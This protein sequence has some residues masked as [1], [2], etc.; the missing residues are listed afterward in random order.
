MRSLLILFVLL[1]PLSAFAQSVDTPP[2]LSRE[3]P[4]AYPERALTDKREANVLLS[5]DID[6]TGAVTRV[7][8]VTPSDAPGYGFEAAAEEALRKFQFEPAR[9]GAT[10]VAVRVQ[11]LYRFVLP[12]PVPP[13]QAPIP[14]ETPATESADPPVKSAPTGEL[15]GTV[16]ERGSRS[17]LAGVRVVLERHDEAYEALT[18]ATGRFAFFDLSEGAWMLT[19]ESEG[20]LESRGEEQ[21]VASEQTEVTLYLERS[22]DNPYDVLVESAAP[23][24]DVTRHRLDVR[25]AQTQP[26]SFGDPLM[27]VQ[28]LPGV[29]VLNG[30]N[31]GIAMRGAAPDESSVYLEGFRMP[32]FYHFIGIRSLVA[33]G[34]LESIDVYPGGAP[35][36]YGRQLGGVLEARLKR[37]APDRTHGYA[38]I[39]LL[40]AGAFVE[41]PIGSK[42]AVAA[43]ARFSYIDRVMKALDAPMPRYDDY[44]LLMTA[45]PNARHSLRLLYIGSDDTFRMDTDDLREE[46]AQITFGSIEAEAHMQHVAFEHEYTPSS[47]V[48]NRAR[49]GYLHWNTLTQFGDEG[50]V[51]IDYDTLL[52][53]DSLRIT[54][55][56]W[57]A[58]DMGVDAELGRWATDVL[59]SPPSKE[60]EAGAYVDYEKEKRAYDNNIGHYAA[61]AWVNLE[62]RPHRDWLLVPGVRAD[63][64]PQIGTLTADPRVSVRYQVI[65]ALA[66]KAGTGVHHAAPTIDESAKTFGNPN[67]GAE[68]SLQH[69]AGVEV[70]PMEELELNLTGFYHQLDGLAAKSSRIR[71]EGDRI[72][73]LEYEN[74]G[75]GRAYGLEVLLKKQLSHRISGFV[76]YTLARAERRRVAGDEYRLFDADQTHNLVLL[77][78]YHLPRH[79]KLSTRFRYRSGQ[80]TTPVVGATFVS[81]NDEYAPS[82]GRT[83]SARNASFQQLDLRVDKAWVFDRWSFTAYLDVQNVYNYNNS[84]AIA[85]N[86]DYSKSG[87]VG[88]VPLLPIVGIK[89]EY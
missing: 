6:A 77:A 23:K 70:K 40:D 20:Y 89:A 75:E 33:P 36:N 5:L 1:L 4:V 59:I 28:N 8:V 86:Y 80:P 34:M 43:A 58:A 65:D 32:L 37:L 12:P 51:N 61:G 57:L 42:V 14:T 17:H 46:S 26:G 15:A 52:F 41:T 84:S 24:R 31:G 47:V 55:A 25:E 73:P 10:P 63:A 68:R 54:P 48:S 11:Y 87:K 30:D 62:L 2:K 83:N 45:R 74:T 53:R 13:P 49:V 67:I 72:I 38:D 27:A 44:Q 85:Y 35:V 56:T 18:D 88:A 29:A 21:V 71:L 7:G 76:A 16:L 82:F 78:A 19:V 79:W 64:Q 69:S 9:A 22:A 39:S 50:R 3:A 81:D 60:G 66:L